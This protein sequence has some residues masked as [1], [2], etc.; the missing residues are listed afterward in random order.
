MG[1]ISG[2]KGQQK[3]KKEKCTSCQKTGLHDPFCPSDLETHDADTMPGEER[4][5]SA[6]YLTSRTDKVGRK[7]IQ[8]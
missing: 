5:K 3:R 1:K 4:E 8:L 7:K 6:A 2:E